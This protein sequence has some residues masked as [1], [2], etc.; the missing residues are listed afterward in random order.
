MIYDVLTEH[1][2]KIPQKTK[3]KLSRIKVIRRRQLSVIE[4]FILSVLLE[5]IQI[6]IEL[7]LQMASH[8]TT[9]FIF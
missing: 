3:V 8:V 2:E 7:L 4:Y 9:S 5:F 1:G 6:I